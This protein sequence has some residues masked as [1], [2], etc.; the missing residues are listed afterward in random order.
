MA[1][2]QQSQ[3]CL[4]RTPQASRCTIPHVHL[5]STVPYMLNVTAVHPGGASSSL[6]AFVAERIS[7]CL[8]S[9]PPPPSPSHGSSL[10]PDPTPPA[11]C[12]V[13]TASI[14]WLYSHLTCFLL[15]PLGLCTA[16]FV[17]PPRSLL[18]YWPLPKS[19]SL[20]I[21]NSHS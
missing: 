13:P 10:S 4:Q 2:Q 19:V 18:Q 1:T 6:L 9:L 5:F 7:E 21:S 15:L 8:S 20:N 16:S 11:S 12:L 17:G 14:F 3:P